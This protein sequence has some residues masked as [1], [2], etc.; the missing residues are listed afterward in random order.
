MAQ[1]KYC[2]KLDFEGYL[3]KNIKYPNNFF[4]DIKINKI[5]ISLKNC[6]TLDFEGYPS[7]NLKYPYLKKSFSILKWVQFQ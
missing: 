2:Q 7:N 6:Q 4:F 5:S 1:L 3:N